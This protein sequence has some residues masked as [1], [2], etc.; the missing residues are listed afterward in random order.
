MFFS[1]VLSLRTIIYNIH[2]SLPVCRWMADEGT[3]TIFGPRRR[4]QLHA[5]PA[6][7]GSV[8]CVEVGTSDLEGLN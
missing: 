8:R 5:T 4:T 3:K 2:T 6:P 1:F 7:T